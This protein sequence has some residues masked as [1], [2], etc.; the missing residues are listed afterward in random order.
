M[1]ED[2][3]AILEAVVEKKMKARGQ[4]QPQRK[5]RHPKTSAVAYDIEEWMQGLVGDSDGEPK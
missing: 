1:Q 2:H 3:H 4:G 5:V